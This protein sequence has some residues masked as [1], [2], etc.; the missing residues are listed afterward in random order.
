MPRICKAVA[1]FLLAGNEECL[2][3]FVA[4]ISSNQQRSEQTESL[5]HILQLSVLHKMHNPCQE[6][7]NLLM[8][9]SVSGLI[10]LQRLSELLLILKTHSLAGPKGN[11]P[12]VH[13]GTAEL[14]GLCSDPRTCRSAA[15]AGRV[16]MQKRVFHPGAAADPGNNNAVWATHSPRTRL[17]PTSQSLYSPGLTSRPKALKETAV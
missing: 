4:S 15:P 14:G 17:G 10:P 16:L 2:A 11:A 6:R 12:P 1:G 3:D 13:E 9:P 8:C 5:Q 7:N